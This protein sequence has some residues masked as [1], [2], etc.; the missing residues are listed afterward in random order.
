M[1][2]KKTL[3]AIKQALC[4][5]E[6]LDDCWCFIVEPGFNYDTEDEVS[7]HDVGHIPCMNKTSDVLGEPFWVAVTTDHGAACPRCK[8]EVPESY[9][10]IQHLRNL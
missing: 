9:R 8:E 2:N 10:M 1:L 7:Y 6:Y 5:V 3:R 4:D